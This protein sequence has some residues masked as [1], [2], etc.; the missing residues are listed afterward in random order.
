MLYIFTGL[1]RAAYNGHRLVKPG[2][3]FSSKVSHSQSNCVVD[4]LAD[5]FDLDYSVIIIILLL[6]LSLSLF[7][8]IITSFRQ[9]RLFQRKLRL[10]NF[11][12]ALSLQERCV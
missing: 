7:I 5:F 4:D 12:T 8:N 11:Q 2:P 1:H 3:I 9:R 10:I 6:L